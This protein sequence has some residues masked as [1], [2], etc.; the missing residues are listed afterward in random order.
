M[1]LKKSQN[2]RALLTT[3]GWNQLIDVEVFNEGDVC[4]FHFNNDDDV[5]D[6]K[7]HVLK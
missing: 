7:I 3:T 2:D 5:L 1:R 6:L 4:I